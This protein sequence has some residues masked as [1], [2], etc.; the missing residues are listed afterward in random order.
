MPEDKNKDGEDAV[1]V[2][3]PRGEW[4]EEKVVNALRIKSEKWRR[5][6][7]SPDAM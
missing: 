3:D 2:L 6:A 1:P 7:T 5:M 4:F